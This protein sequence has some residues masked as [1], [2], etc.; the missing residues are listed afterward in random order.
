MSSNGFNHRENQFVK[1]IVKGGVPFFW[2]HTLLLLYTSLRVT[3]PAVVDRVN[4]SV[5]DLFGVPNLHWGSSEL[6]LN[7]QNKEDQQKRF[8]WSTIGWMEELWQV[9][10]GCAAKISSLSD[11]W[12]LYFTS[13]PSLLLHRIMYRPQQPATFHRPPVVLIARKYHWLCT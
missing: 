11:M 13:G 5:L 6:V 3:I 2:A 4:W 9:P 10:N 7:R 8:E 12:H 1:Y